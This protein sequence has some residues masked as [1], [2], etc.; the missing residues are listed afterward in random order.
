MKIN[1]P[2]IGYASGIAAENEGCADGPLVLKHNDLQQQFATFGVDAY[3]LDMLYPNKTIK[4]KYRCVADLANRL[5]HQT[6][7][8]V[9]QQQIF[10][11]IG[12]DHSSAIGTWSGVAFACYSR[13]AIG[14]IW[15]DAHLDSHTTDTSESGNIHGMPLACLLGYGD[16]SLTTVAYAKTKLLPQNVAIIGARSF[17][18]GELNL[19][20]KLGVRIFLEKEVEKIGVAAALAE[21]HR[22]ATHVTVGYGLSIDMDAIDPADAPGVG[23]PEPNGISSKELYQSLIKYSDDTALLGIEIAEFNP[24]LDQNGLTKNAVVKLLFSLLQRRI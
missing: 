17:E 6:K 11:V 3:W 20:E 1:L 10:A 21:A 16:P 8:L 23:T 5:S 13:G 24:H 14:L 19:L 12:G 9:E 2:L 15:I 7:T 18:Q 4:N 22:I